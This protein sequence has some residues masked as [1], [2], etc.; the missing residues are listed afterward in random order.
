MTG[1]PTLPPSGHGAPQH[2]WGPTPP[3][4]KKPFPWVPI[5][6]IGGV[7]LL[8]GLLCL[9]VFV[10]VVGAVGAAIPAG[11]F[12][13]AAMAE[14]VEV[15]SSELGPHWTQTEAA[16][17]TAV[18]ELDYATQC[19][20]D[21]T[22]LD[23]QVMF[24]SRFSYQPQSGNEAGHLYY[25]VIGS[26]DEQTGAAQHAAVSAAAF[27]PCVEKRAR[28]IYE[29]MGDVL[30]IRVERALASKTNDVAIVEYRTFVKIQADDEG[31]V[32]YYALTTD[33]LRLGSNRV[34]MELSTELN[35]KGTSTPSSGLVR[36]AGVKRLHDW[37]GSK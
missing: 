7:V 6:L 5:L 8:V 17:P 30:D 35:V 14:A 4:R 16:M 18:T 36:D 27:E 34:R 20:P 15:R 22:R 31:T 2:G 33:Y 28:A 21:D 11:T 12:E 1:G 25:T 32:H 26:T 10:K 13:N 24:V 23:D 3:Q 29:E 37:G 19:A 9:V